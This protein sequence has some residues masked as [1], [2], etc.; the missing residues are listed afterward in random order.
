M[1]K[2][3]AKEIKAIREALNRIN[4]VPLDEIVF[5][6]PISPEQVEEYKL[7]GLNNFNILEMVMED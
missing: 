5:D 2:V 1:I 7:T 4:S 6:I 3:T